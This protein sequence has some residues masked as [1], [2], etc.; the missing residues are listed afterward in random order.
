MCMDKP[1]L[2]FCGGTGSRRHVYQATLMQ[3]PD[4]DQRSSVDINF[5]RTNMTKW[6]YLARKGTHGVFV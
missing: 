2:V 6:N 1:L 5:S 3:G 4:P